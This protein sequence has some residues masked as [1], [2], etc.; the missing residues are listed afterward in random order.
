MSL[1]YA[2]RKQVMAY[3]KNKAR[4]EASLY[5]ISAEKSDAYVDAVR[6]KEYEMKMKFEREGREKEIQRQAALGGFKGRLKRSLKG[7]GKNIRENQKRIKR[8]DSG[9]MG[10]GRS[11][12]PNFGVNQAAF[13][14]KVGVGVSSSKKKGKGLWDL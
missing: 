9:S 3:K 1:G 12:G 6:K 7:V 2:V 5:G 14:V 8:R 4:K 11:S 10:G 13:D